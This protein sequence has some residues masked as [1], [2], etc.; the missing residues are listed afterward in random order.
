MRR[1]IVLWFRRWWCVN[2]QKREWSELLQIPK[3]TCA[4]MNSPLWKQEIIKENKKERCVVFQFTS[5]DGDVTRAQI[6]TQQPFFSA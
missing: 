5:P 1:K 3:N 2:V 4:Y 6:S